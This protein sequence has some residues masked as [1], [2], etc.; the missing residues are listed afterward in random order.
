[1]LANWPFAGYITSNYDG[2]LSRALRAIQDEAPAWTQVGNTPAEIRKLS[3]DAQRRVWHIHGAVDLAPDR[4]KLVLTSS[5]YDAIYAPGSAV[6]EQ[7][8]AVLAVRRLVFVGFGF[9]DL[10][11][12]DVLQKVALLTEP[13]RPII[14]VLPDSVDAEKR[15]SLSRESNVDIL[16]YPVVDANHD[17]LQDLIQ[18]HDYVVFSRSQHLQQPSLPC[19]SFDE[20]A[21]GLFLYSELCL[22][23]SS[24]IKDDV[25]LPLLKMKVLSHL[26][27]NPTASTTDLAKDIQARVAAIK[28]PA[29]QI[30]EASGMAQEMSGALLGLHQ[31]GLIDLVEGANVRLTTKGADIVRSKRTIAERY[32]DAFTSSLLARVEKAAPT[33]DSA[34]VHRVLNTAESF[35]KDSVRRRALAVATALTTAN[36]DQKQSSVVGLLQHLREYISTMYSAE[37]ALPLITTIMDVL[38]DASTSER[39]YIAVLLQATFATSL[40]GLDAATIRAR[41]REIRNTAFILDASVLVPYFAVGSAGHAAAKSLV[42]KLLELGCSVFTTSDF[43]REVT[44]HALTAKNYYRSDA[45]Q[46][47]KIF[48]KVRGGTG[49][50]NAFVEGFHRSSNTILRQSGMQHYL[51]NRCGL[52]LVVGPKSDNLV[53]VTSAIEAVGVRVLDTQQLDADSF[54]RAASYERD[55]RRWRESNASLG[56]TEQPL[57]EANAT[58]FVENIRTRRVPGVLCA[59]SFFVTSTRFVDT[60]SSAKVTFAPETLHQF[61]ITLGGWSSDELEVLG[62]NLVSELMERGIVVLT[63][64]QISTIFLP[65]IDLSKDALAHFLER[66]RSLALAKWGGDELER[67]RT[68]SDADLPVLNERVHYQMLIDLERENAR[69]RV[70]KQQNAKASMLTQQEA[71]ELARYRAKAR[72]RSKKKHR[73]EKPTKA[74]KAKGSS[75]STPDSNDNT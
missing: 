30:D 35:L 40:L 4:S 39:Q 5:D 63:D 18:L 3:G 55:I 46:T 28:G 72:D 58:V 10:H 64:R 42:E 27:T 21:T 16:L 51:V 44:S 70:S 47:T 66:Y 60:L 37:E 71:N 33:L 7:L 53:I 12:L 31:E 25:L 57:A 69:L 62:A 50:Q 32:S 8:K 11:L 65:L 56:H 73:R 22:V 45:P 6:L 20:E 1:M 17:K 52:A 23:D 43:V 54:T 2:L 49:R 75:G 61:L 29:A 13:A 41:V 9:N 74:E 59:Q 19:P 15:Y 67:W 34:Q 36:E 48:D 14:A 24:Q 38:L 26:S 68:V